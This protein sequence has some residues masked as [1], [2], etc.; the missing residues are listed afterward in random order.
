MK[1]FLAV[2]F[3]VGCFS[4]SGQQT[5]FLNKEITPFDEK[6]PQE[7]FWID[8]LE[9]LTEETVS[10]TVKK[11]S[12]WVHVQ[13]S[14]DPASTDEQKKEYIRQLKIKLKKLEL[15]KSICQIKIVSFDI[16]EQI[17]LT[18][19]EVKSGGENWKKMAKA[20]LDNA[21]KELS[22]VLKGMFPQAKFYADNWG[23]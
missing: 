19:K 23:W 16:G 7:F 18:Q 15:L 5:T 9:K 2:T 22:P 11:E 13:F 12:Q 10:A 20:N 6:T 21:W 3:I 4:A 1:L 8:D 17:F 14:F